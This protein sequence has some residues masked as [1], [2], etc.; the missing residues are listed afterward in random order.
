[1]LTGTWIRGGRPNLVSAIGSKDRMIMSDAGAGTYERYGNK[2]EGWTATYGTTF[3]FASFNGKN[4]FYC[5]VLEQPQGDNLKME[6]SDQGKES[7][8]R[9]SGK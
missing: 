9:D 7:W 3:Y 4:D 1:V 2:I 6:C 8:R 5:S